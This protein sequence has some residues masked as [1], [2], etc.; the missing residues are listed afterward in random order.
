MSDIIKTE[1]TAKGHTVNVYH[2]SDV[3]SPRDEFG[4]MSTFFGFHARYISPDKA[5][6]SDPTKARRIAEN[7]E[8]ICLPVWLYDH[9]GTDYTACVS[10]PYHCRWD[11]GLFG[12]IFISRADAR[13]RY[14]AKRISQRLL[15]EIKEDLASEVRT[16]SKWANGECYCHEVRD[17]SGEVVGGC[18][19]WYDLDGALT[20]GMQ[21]AYALEGESK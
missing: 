2:D 11:S 5:P 17:E 14:G 13:H 16:Y 3:E 8:N 6:D 12:F 1:T 21:E 15:V 18:G 19:G 9:S 20:D 4:P 7:A 10:N